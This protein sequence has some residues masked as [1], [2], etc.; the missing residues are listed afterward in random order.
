LVRPIV[1]SRAARSP[2]PAPARRILGAGAWLRA[3]AAILLV[4][5]AFLACL[6][7]L[8]TLTPAGVGDD[9]VYVRA[10]ED[11]LR[12]G[13]VR[14]LD[15]AVVTLLFQTAWGG[16]FAALVAP[17]GIFGA[18]RLSTIAI[19]AIGGVALYGLCRELGARRSWAALAAAAY[20]FNPL[21]FVLAWTF[22]TDPFFAALLTVAAWWSAK[23]TK[24][25]PGAGRWLV[26]GSVAAAC[27]FLVRHQ[28]A[29]IPPAVLFGLLLAGR[30]RPDR[31]G[32]ATVLRVAAIPAATVL[33]YYGWLFNLHG[34]PEQQGQFASKMVAAGWGESLLLV[35]RLAVIAAMYLGLFAL[36]LA[37][38]MAAA[39]AGRLLPARSLSARFAPRRPLP[40]RRPPG[41]PLA[42]R[43]PPGRPLATRP[44]VARSLAAPPI[45]RWRSAWGWAA[46]AG[47]ALLLGFGILH[48][49]RQGLA[50]PPMPLMPYVPQYLG[51]SGLGPND[52]LGGRPDLIGWRGLAG[53]TA[54]C[55]AASL[56]WALLVARAFA[57]GA[58]AAGDRPRSGF[59][60]RWDPATAG[61]RARRGTRFRWGSVAAAGRPRS[62]AWFRRLPADG[63]AADPTRAAALVVVC[64]LA[65]QA[66]GTLPPSFHF[67]NWIVS[68]DRYL[69]PLLPLALALGVWALRGSGVRLGPA[70]ATVALGG[71]LAFAGTR[72]FLL[73]Q[74]ATWDL[75]RWALAAG[76]PIERLDAGASWDGYHLYELGQ[77][78][79]TPTRTENP[80]WWVDLFAPATDS[81]WVVAT[82]D[83]PG[84]Q[85]VARME[86]DS[87]LLGGPQPLFLLRRDGVAGP[88]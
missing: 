19:T 24:G 29:L 3:H 81:A 43:R 9:W 77:A 51:S 38:G 47:W 66:A 21:A 36:P 84:Y 78:S 80:P 20:L 70:W 71:V 85:A 83:R 17:L 25:G 79:G 87:W 11:L 28:G 69:L 53:L 50:P 46:V 6:P 42:A 60:R 4:L 18:T 40:A 72:D 39:L 75:A 63:N 23:G 5:G 82:T 44:L 10:V 64:L 54:V 7:L 2:Q 32:L 8:P 34:V 73:F 37:V 41:R 88:P 55:A 33:L 48:F 16:L 13:E 62:G 49:W 74:G 65:A 57:P 27:S 58:T 61:S 31:A 26:A 30:L 1:R 12:R 52:L 35:G 59:R 45:W 67:R 22:M 68:V 86:V 15:L 56:L 76:V 14:K